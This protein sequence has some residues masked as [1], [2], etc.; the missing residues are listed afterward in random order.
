LKERLDKILVSRGLVRGRELAK[1]LVME[2]KIF[3]DGKKIT[4]PGTPVSDA[5]EIL[6]KE[7]VKP[8]VSRGGV[9]LEAALI[10]FN[11][12]VTGKILMSVLVQAVLQTVC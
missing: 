3:V 12:D 4:K 5:S 2:G 7:E 10:F 6:L 11:A 9:K 8:Y 1:A